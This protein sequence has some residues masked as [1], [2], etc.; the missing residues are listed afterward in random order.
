M[1]DPH[2]HM[3][4][5]GRVRP[6]LAPGDDAAGAS[7]Q[8]AT[9]R[10]TSASRRAAPRAALSPAPASPPPPP[11]PPLPAVHTEYSFSAALGPEAGQE[12]VF[13]AVRGTLG[14]ALA[15]GQ[16]CVIFAYGQTGSG[17]TYTMLGGGSFR[18]RGLM[19]R[20][21][22]LVFAHADAAAA[23]AAAAA[24]GAPPPLAVA[25]SFAEV[26]G[27]GAYDLLG[28]LPGAAAEVAAG[29]PAAGV[30]A[31]LAA[32][33]SGAAR[34]A[35]PL[36]QWPR[37]E[38]LEG[39]G[40]TLTCRGL[41]TWAVGS[42]AAALGLLLAGHLAR[43]T[44]ATPL[45]QA[46]SRSHALLTITLA[47]A[48]PGAGGAASRIYLVDLA[49][50]ERVFKGGSGSGSG[51]GS[52]GAAA[53]A[54]AAAVAMAGGSGEGGG[55]GAGAWQRESTQ[56]NLS[57]HCLELV[58]LA[59]AERQAAERAG[60][61]AA[62]GAAAASAAF[63]AATAAASGSSSS[64]ESAAGGL[65]S[66]HSLASLRSS[67][68]A[69]GAGAGA[70]RQARSH[71]VPSAARRPSLSGGSVAS[72]SGSFT[73]SGA[74]ASLYAG[75]STVSAGSRG[76]SR[77]SGE[78]GGGGGGARAR[79]GGSGSAF[80]SSARS[81]SALRRP[82]SA[83]AAAAPA[84]AAHVHIP[85]RNSVLTSL[86]RDAL[87]SACRPVLIACVA[88]ELAHGEESNSTCRFAARCGLME[89]FTSAAA[90]LSGGGGRGSGRGGGS[91]GSGSSG[92]GSARVEELQAL[93]RA[94]AA[95]ERALERRV[96]ELEAAAAGAG[97][98][99]AAGAAD[100]GSLPPAAASAAG[101]GSG[102]Q[103]ASEPLAPAAQLGAV[104]AAVF[105]FLERPAAAAAA[106]GGGAGGG[107]A[108][109]AARR[110]ALE[111]AL[112]DTPVTAAAATAAAAATLPL[113]TWSR[114]QCLYGFLLLR[115]AVAAAVAVAGGSAGELEA[116]RARAE[117]AE[118]ALLAQRAAA[119]AGQ[120]S[121]GGT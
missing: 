50:S 47:P 15:A 104:E 65:A 9:L 120:G 58:M 32:L 86:L 14:A 93:L 115:E 1:D 37:V 121:S 83:A 78:G 29:P 119:A 41:R 42:E 82:G 96:A 118:Q 109:G 101:G 111:L 87:S 28:H 71:S 2:A 70:A 18:T 108:R 103:G 114:Q 16:N 85:Y 36:E 63:L 53:A 84:P 98:G 39:E 66:P 62:A 27:E 19:Q 113:E 45:N 31:R 26:Y 11:P 117:G 64:S 13:A 40:G 76:R 74:L 23:A 44:S 91:S 10:I 8:G 88:P 95:R 7:V 5:V 35:A 57:L 77:A 81:R 67:S 116:L 12:D 17:K 68:R 30:G 46:S 79:L 43:A 56:I 24:P 69:V 52:G 99:G 97:A 75:E 48:A 94:Q 25:L 54:A 105:A 4:V 92:S 33:A 22:G 107:A 60:A 72:A 102:G 3:L 61:G 20:V 90:P 51:S 6:L 100:A 80:G 110:V 38:L 34:A 112:P 89:A 106:A 21:L 59:L 49:G 55:G 73:G